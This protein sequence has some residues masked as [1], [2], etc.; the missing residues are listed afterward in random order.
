MITS[1]ASVGSVLALTEYASEPELLKAMTPI[2]VY[3]QKKLQIS[4]RNMNCSN[5]INGKWP[6]AGYSNEE[7]ERL[8]KGGVATGKGAGAD[9]RFA[10]ELRRSAQQVIYEIT[11]TLIAARR[12]PQ[13]LYRRA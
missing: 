2:G 6:T 7:H 9:R 10:H 4:G 12:V 8:P 5:C 11:Q 3:Y 13:G 1:C